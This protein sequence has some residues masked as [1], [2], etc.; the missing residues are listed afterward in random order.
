M[1]FIERFSIIVFSIL[2]L[3]FSIF[4][5]FV[6]CDIVNVSIFE[7]IFEYL[8]EN[9]VYTI[10]ISVVLSLWSIANIFVKSDSKNSNTNGILLENENGS[11]LITKDSISNLVGAVLKK[12]TDVK[13]ESIKIDFDNNKNIVINIVISVKDS[14]IIKDTSAKL[15]E[16]IKMIVK[17]ATDLEVKEINIKIK[18]VEQEKKVQ[19]AQ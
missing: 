10:C 17:K 9:M 13:E 12:S 18:G 6:T 14:T 15:Q 16:S 19:T 1:R 2:I 4:T 8:S 3:V 5:M 7:D 11:L